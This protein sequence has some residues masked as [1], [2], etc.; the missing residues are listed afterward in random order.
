V[1]AKAPVFGFTLVV[2]ADPT[3]AGHAFASRSQQVENDFV[4]N[5]LYVF[6]RFGARLFS[7]GALFIDVA[8]VLGF[9]VSVSASIHRIGE[10]MRCT[11]E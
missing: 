6:S 9:A 8:L 5:S 1:T 10:D 2:F 11:W 7:D 4:R 3:H